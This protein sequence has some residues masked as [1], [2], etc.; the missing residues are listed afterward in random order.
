MTLKLIN[1]ILETQKKT[2]NKNSTQKLF[3]NEKN[4]SIKTEIKLSK[5]NLNKIQK[6]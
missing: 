2:K 6:N 4:V 3:L 1:K 5:S